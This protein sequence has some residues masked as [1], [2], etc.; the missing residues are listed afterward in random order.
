MKKDY[1]HCKEVINKDMADFLYQY[2]LLKR[3]GFLTLYNNHLISRFDEDRGKWGDG[4]VDNSFCIYG[5]SMFD[6]LLVKIKPV[7][8]KQTGV[9]LIET[10]SYARVYQTGEDLK[11]HRDRASCKI[12]S[13]MNLGGDPWKIYLE[14]E[15][16]KT[17]SFEL[18]PGDMLIYKGDK[19]KHWRKTF[20]GT[21]CGQVF[22][23]YNDALDLT[24]KFDGRPH[25][26]LP[27]DIQIEK[28]VG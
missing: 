23:H 13:T 24:N 7:M 12:S 8:E 25:L 3:Q 5:D 16:K 11:K 26:G 9:K 6:L 18:N 27:K 22:L 28:N 2:L 14:L 20:K 19:L 17:K 10:Y 4:Q 1:I 21:A 15:D